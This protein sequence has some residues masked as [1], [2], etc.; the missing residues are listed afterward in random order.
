[1]ACPFVMKTRAQ[2]TTAFAELDAG[3]SG[4]VPR[5]APLMSR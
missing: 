5:Q 2:I 4:A 3:T 1:M